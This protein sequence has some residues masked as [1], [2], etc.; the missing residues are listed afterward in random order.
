MS[1]GG[2]GITRRERIAFGAG[3]ITVAIAAFSFMRVSYISPLINFIVSLILGV[4]T[5]VIVLYMFPDP[6][7][8]PGEIE[9][10]TER[11][12]RSI[13]AEL[14]T[15]AERIRRDRRSCDVSEDIANQLAAISTLA[16]S[17]ADRYATRPR[18]FAGAAST[19]RVLEV[20]DAVLTYYHRIKCGGL[21][22]D[23]VRSEFEIEQVETRVIPMVESGLNRQA[24]Q[25][26]SGEA[27]DMS[28][29]IRTLEDM[30]QSLNLIES[31]S[32]TLNS[33]FLTE[34]ENDESD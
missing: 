15:I 25:L 11:R 31:M 23:P 28:A 20:S 4:S 2:S 3:V 12:Y 1:R 18:N 19:L 8:D 32:S 29:Q 14:R 6:D 13:I 16:H 30:L 9:R 10:E 17:L 26:D 5:A 22:L 27:G 33:P 34:G 7:R 21:L 24:R